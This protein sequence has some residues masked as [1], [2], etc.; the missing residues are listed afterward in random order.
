MLV[1]QNFLGQFC[2]FTLPFLFLEICIQDSERSITSRYRREGQR[3][4]KPCCYKRMLGFP[5]GPHLLWSLV[6]DISSQSHSQAIIPP[7]IQANLLGSSSVSLALTL[8]LCRSN[9][10]LFLS[11]CPSQGQGKVFDA[12]PAT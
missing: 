4:S 2:I 5:A 12:S 8:R 10:P 6:W 9:S 1:K 7:G 11:Q 3:A